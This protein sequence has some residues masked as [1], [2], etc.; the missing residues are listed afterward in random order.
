[1]FALPRRR[2]LLSAF[3]CL[4]VCVCA[5]LLGASRAPAQTQSNAADLQ[6]FVRDAQGAVVPSASV[7]AT[8]RTTGFTRTSQTNDEG[9]YQIVN[10]PPGEYQVTVEA[11]NFSKADVPSVILQ[12]GQRADLEIP[13]QAGQITETVIISD[14]TTNIVETSKT[15]VSNIIDEQRIDNLPINERSATGFALTLSTVGRDNGRPIGPA[16][17]SGLNIG[18][19][20][21]RSTQVNV[22]GADFTDNSVNAARTTVSQEAV[23][24]YQVATNSYAPEFGRATGGVV[25]VVTKGG[26]NDVRGNLFGFIR[27]KSIQARNAFAPLIDND[28]GKKP[29]FTR[30]QYGATIGGP[31]KRDRT[32]F[33][34]SFEQRRR[35][36]SGFFTS[37]VAQGLGGSVTIGAPFLPF[38]QT[39]R[40]IT[41]PQSGYVNG[42]LSQAAA[43]IGTGIP[44]NVALGQQLAGA[45]IQYATLASS[46]GST[47]LN[48]TNPLVSPGGAIPAG[49]PIGQRF[50]LSGAPVPVS[51]TA[52][53]P[54]SQLARVFPIS[55][56][57]TFSSI[58][59][60]HKI[61]DGNQLTMRFGY[62][63]SELT[64]IQVE[65]QNQSLGQNDFSRT[66][67]QT[68][69]D[70]SFVTTLNSVL[71][72]RLVN[73]ARFSFGKRKA[74]F[75]SQNNDAVAV[76]IADTAFF[77]REAFS[78][79]VRT[80]NRYQYT[81]NLSLV[82]G[83]HTFKFGGDANFISVDASFELN[84]VGLYN[85]GNFSANNLA[86]FPAGAP[87]FTPVQS[88]G[89]GLPSIY[90]QG[91]GNPVSQLKNRPYALYA[92]DSWKI[93]PN[94][95]LNYGVRYD[96]E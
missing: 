60:D 24:E 33:F 52:F 47:A 29:P 36:E 76:N 79:V 70:T 80:E 34:F 30:A 63:P 27:H 50:F 77:G 83:D 90:V 72:N 6:G 31:L 9:F 41:A 26:T 23:Q 51:P 2:M 4:L 43:L 58:R 96:Y 74:T 57:T 67:I 81:D 32:F 55:D 92:Q 53:R 11:A 42:L 86:A 69:K 82:A 93:R 71:S 20:R 54:L 40:N 87:D 62:N 7:T 48:G 8:N 25:N 66:G 56:D 85:F 18:G 16:P 68:L 21:G 73:E 28:P 5:L 39:Y 1:M 95:T 59:L 38:S 15:N 65:S 89:L 12:V 49:Q 75:K 17:S 14:A 35:Q 13:L 22:D 46:G 88:Y 91:F 37:D 94:F 64:G 19:Q 10:L 44:A 61:T 45:A 3:R 84:F 78:P